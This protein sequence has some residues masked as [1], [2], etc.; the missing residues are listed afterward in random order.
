MGN[1]KNDLDPEE[2]TDELLDPKAP[3]DKKDSHNFKNNRYELLRNIVAMQL[4]ACGTPRMVNKELEPR[5]LVLNCSE[6]LKNPESLIDEF[7]AIW[8]HG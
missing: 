1:L 7:E 2:P 3:T 6:F 4:Y 5:E 8:K